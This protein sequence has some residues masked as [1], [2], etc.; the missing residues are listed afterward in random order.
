MRHQDC[1]ALLAKFKHLHSLCSYEWTEWHWAGH[2]AKNPNYPHPSCS[3]KRFSW[4]LLRGSRVTTGNY[5]LVSELSSLLM[6]EQEVSVWNMKFK[7]V[8]CAYLDRGDICSAKLI[9]CQVVT[10]KDFYR[11]TQKESR[12]CCF[13][14]D[15]RVCILLV[16]IR[17]QHFSV[18]PRKEVVE[19]LQRF[20]DGLIP[21][22][23]AVILTSEDHKKKGPLHLY[24]VVEH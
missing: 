15:V 24:A 23:P 22:V 20:S 21:S 13:T 16:A 12:V 18:I 6:H 7:P 2:H 11:R 17:N 3:P 8:F 5:C 9:Y 10:W 1:R 14:Q 19:P 4:H